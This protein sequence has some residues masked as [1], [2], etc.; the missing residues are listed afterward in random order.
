MNKTN[1]NKA[2]LAGVY[3]TGALSGAMIYAVVDLL[4]TI[5]G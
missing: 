2:L 4:I 5:L 3:L 1:E